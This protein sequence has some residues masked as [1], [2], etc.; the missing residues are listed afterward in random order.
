M[1]AGILIIL[2]RQK[3]RACGSG[4]GACTHRQC[5]LAGSSDLA[6]TRVQGCFSPAPLAGRCCPTPQQGM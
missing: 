6:S 3:D 2:Q 4:R 5:I 1:F